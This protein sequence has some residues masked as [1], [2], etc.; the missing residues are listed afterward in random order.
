MILSRFIVIAMILTCVRGDEDYPLE[1]IM[2]D[3]GTGMAVAAWEKNAECSSLMSTVTMLALVLALVS[4]CLCPGEIDDYEEYNNR[5]SFKRGG[6]MGAG[7]M[8]GR[9]VF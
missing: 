8:I 2:F 3:V 6:A 7:Y 5:K 4:W 1:E 9:Q